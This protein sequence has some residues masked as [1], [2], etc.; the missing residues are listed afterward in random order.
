[1]ELLMMPVL[2]VIIMFFSRLIKDKSD[3]EK[4]KLFLKFSGTCFI[5]TLIAFAGVKILG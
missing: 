5:L 1:M 3:E 4:K 2:A